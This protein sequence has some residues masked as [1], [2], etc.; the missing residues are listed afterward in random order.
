ME[1]C[2]NHIVTHAPYI[3]SSPVLDDNPVCL[4]ILTKLRNF[5][6]FVFKPKIATE[7][8]ITAESAFGGFNE[9]C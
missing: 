7:Y 1:E 8:G 3:W 4:N 6:I 2:L 5:V 9:M